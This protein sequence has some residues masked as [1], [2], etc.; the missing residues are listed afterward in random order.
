MVEAE[1]QN[2]DQWKCGVMFSEKD[3]QSNEKSRKAPIGKCWQKSILQFC[4]G[5]SP[6]LIDPMYYTIPNV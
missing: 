5:R 6:I 4:Y 3:I 2:P 1:D